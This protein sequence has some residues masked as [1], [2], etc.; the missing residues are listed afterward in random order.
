MLFDTTVVIEASPRVNPLSTGIDEWV[1]KCISRVLGD[2]AS[3][4]NPGRSEVY[5]LAYVP[6]RVQDYARAISTI[7]AQANYHRRRFIHDGQCP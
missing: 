1:P 4:W 6:A 2:R 7:Q 5:M 3:K